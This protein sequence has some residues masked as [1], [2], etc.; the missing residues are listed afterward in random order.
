MAQT[1]KVSLKSIEYERTSDP[2]NA[3]GASGQ[4]TAVATFGIDYDTSGRNNL[5]FDLIVDAS[6]QELEAPQLCWAELHRFAELLTALALKNLR[7]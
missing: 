6:G 3:D 2:A 7:R 4:V 1:Y 5:S